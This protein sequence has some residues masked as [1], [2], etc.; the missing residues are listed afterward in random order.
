MRHI[1]AVQ[2][3]PLHTLKLATDSTYLLMQEALRRDWRIF[4]YEPKDLS[5]LNGAPHAKGVFLEKLTNTQGQ[6]ATTSDTTTLPLAE[7]KIVLLRQDPPFNMAYISSTYILERLPKST[8]VL[9]N[10]TSVRNAPEKLLVTE[11]PDLTPPTLITT[12]KE[13]ATAFR[14]AQGDVV[15]KPLYGHGG[16]HVFHVQAGDGN[17]NGLFDLLLQHEQTPII[18]QRYLPAVRQGDKRIILLNGLPIAALNRVPPQGQVRANTASGG[19]PEL[20]SLTE[21]DKKIC[22]QIGPRLRELG[23]VLVGI[24]VIGEYLTEIN[25]TSPTGLV[26]LNK[27]GHTQLER[28]IWDVFMEQ[29]SRA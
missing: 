27:L 1:L 8:L 17:F 15:L 26:L 3:D 16:A 2:A 13:M 23:L 22:A 20:A 25:V 5:L 4:Y 14:Q 10:P 6:P 12:D 19:T 18:V 11:W 7:A 29:V 28:Q 21:H 9:N 24:D